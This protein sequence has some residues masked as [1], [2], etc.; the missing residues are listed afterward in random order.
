MNTHPAKKAMELKIT[1]NEQIVSRIIDAV[2]KA[3]AQPTPDVSNGQSAQLETLQKQVASLQ[4]ELARLKAQPIASQPKAIAQPTISQPK[5]VATQPIA[6]QSMPTE[7]V[8]TPKPSEKPKEPAKP[9]Q[10]AQPVKPSHSAQPATHQAKPN[11]VQSYA[12][13]NGNDNQ[14]DEEKAEKW[15]RENLLEWLDQPCPF[16]KAQGRSWKQL[17]K[18][19]GEKIV[20]KGKLMPPRAYL[21][22][23]ENWD[24]CQA[25]SKLKA[26]VALEFGKNGN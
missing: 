18:N 26:K 6:L 2:V 15:V 5:P 7:Q 8:Q 23:L 13:P 11:E 10:S 12:K 24:E 17:C 1:I 22:V 25:W 19:E 3:I 20:I 9:L 21:H 4:A 14:P 16:A